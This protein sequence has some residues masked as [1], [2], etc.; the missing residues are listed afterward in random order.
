M[1]QAD[2]GQRALQAERRDV[3]TGKEKYL[4]LGEVWTAQHLVG[5]GR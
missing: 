2:E 5:R 3:Q 1:H 4:F